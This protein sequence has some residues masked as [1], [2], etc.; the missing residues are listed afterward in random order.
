MF[1]KSDTFKLQKNRRESCREDRYRVRCR[2]PPR[3]WRKFI[4]AL[5]TLDVDQLTTDNK[6]SNMG[7]IRGPIGSNM[8]PI[9]DNR[10]PARTLSMVPGSRSVEMTPMVWDPNGLGSFWGVG[11]GGPP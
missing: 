2:L 11:G 4:L 3:N 1:S 10:G 7:Q 5:S 8:G 6:G 9:G